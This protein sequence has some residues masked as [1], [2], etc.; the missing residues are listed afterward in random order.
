MKEKYL[1]FSLAL[2]VLF[3]GATGC[4][5]KETIIAS[6]EARN[7]LRV[8]GTGTVRATPDIAQARIGVQTFSESLEEAMSQNNTRSAAVIAALKADGVAERDIQT[9]NLNVSPQRD[10]RKEDGVGQIVGYWVNNT[11]AVTLRDLT[12]VGRILQD[13]ID[14]GANNVNSLIFTLSDPDSLR[15]EARRKAV[16]DARRR[17]EGLAEAAGVELGKPIRIDETSSGGGPIYVRSTFDE[18]AGGSSV[19]VEPGEVEVT[20]Q[21]EVIYEIH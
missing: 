4:N 9:R 2:F 8:L 14:A 17:A 13:A 12:Q 11:V 15:S 5:D 21:V 1:G 3:A 20:V 6:T 10:F 18:A 16:Q 7:Q 19:P